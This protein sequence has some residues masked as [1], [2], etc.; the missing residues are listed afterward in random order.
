[1]SYKW[2]DGTGHFGARQFWVPGVPPFATSD[3]NTLASA[4]AAAWNTNMVGFTSSQYAL[5][6]IDLLDLT[7]TAGTAGLWTGS[8]SGS[9]STNFGTSNCAIDIQAKIATRYRGGHPVFHIPPP[10]DSALDSTR[11]LSESTRTGILAG[12]QAYLTAV[13]GTPGGALNNPAPVILRGYKVGAPPSAVNA[14]SPVGWNIRK[15]LGS[16]RRRLTST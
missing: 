9:G 15:T 16:M 6:E 14:Y 11:T 8:H 3:L 7:N 1:M 2:Y 12:W 4:M 10:S 5:V 13:K